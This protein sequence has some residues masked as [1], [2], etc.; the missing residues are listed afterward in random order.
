MKESKL[1]T[2]FSEKEPRHKNSIQ[3]KRKHQ[4]LDAKQ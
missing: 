4:W 3:D 2:E 1:F